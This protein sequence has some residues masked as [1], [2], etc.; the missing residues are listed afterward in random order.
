MGGGEM[1]TP[2]DRFIY[3]DKQKNAVGTNYLR[4]GIGHEIYLML[5]GEVS[6][7]IDR[8]VYSLEPGDLLVIN[9]NEVH[10][11]S[12]A[13]PYSCICVCFNPEYIS[14]FNTPQYNLLQ[15][16]ENRKS[17]F[18]NKISSEAVRNAGITGLFEN[19]YEWDGSELPEKD[20]MLVSLLLQLIVAV[21][22]IY[23]KTD[24]N[25]EVLRG[26]RLNPK[27]YDIINY[28]T[29]NI[30]RRIMLSELEKVFFINKYYLCRLFKNATGCTVSEYISL[31]KV[32]FAKELLR[33]R[34]SVSNVCGQLGF[35]DY[36]NFYRLFKKYEGVSP[37]DYQKL[38]LERGLLGKDNDN[39]HIV[40]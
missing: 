13:A 2:N 31:R 14:R 19:L 4:T 22:G 24:K 38:C 9:K 36:S 17:G 32:S 8:Q 20:A 28:I 35:E 40:I 12:A 18:G 39:N 10:R 7:N 29:L 27:V 1:P 30:N 37:S 26:E 15:I 25:T 16:F 21:T 11:I 34:Y 6:F 3:A 23:Y 5:E 33:Q